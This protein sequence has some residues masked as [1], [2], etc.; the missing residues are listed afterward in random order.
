MWRVIALQ[1]KA[2]M[3]TRTLQVQRAGGEGGGSEALRLKG[4]P[5]VETIKLEVEIM[6]RSDWNERSSF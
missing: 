3:L 6:R 2:D 1:Y 5:P 4:S